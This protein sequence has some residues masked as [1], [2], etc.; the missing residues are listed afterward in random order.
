MKIFNKLT[1]GVLT[2]TFF[3]G[4]L[5]GISSEARAQTSPETYSEPDNDIVMVYDSDYIRAL[6]RAKNLARMA[7]EQANG[8]LDDYRA[9]SYM[10]GP[11]VEVPFV[12]NGQSWTFAFYGT[13]P[14]SNVPAYKSIVTVSKNGEMVR[15]EYNEP[16]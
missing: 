7:A 15:M 10:H 9:A 12:D 2:S 14:A 3:M 6:N 13:E 5:M 11:A 4:A 1:L 8:G 16:I